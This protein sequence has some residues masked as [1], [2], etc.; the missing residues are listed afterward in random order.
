MILYNISLFLVTVIGGILPIWTNGLN[1]KNMHYLLAF[2][3]SFLLSITFLHLLPE[4]FAALGGSTGMLLLAGFFIQLLIQRLT[5]GTEHGH[6]H[7]SDH[8]HQA[9]LGS[10]AIGLV[11]HAIMDGVPL[12]AH[13]YSEGTISSLYL[14]IASHKLPEAMLV[15]SLVRATRNKAQAFYILLIFSSITPA[16]AIITGYM[17]NTYS[18]ASRALPYLIPIVAG[19]FINIATTIFFESGTRQHKLSWQ[20]VVAMLSGV[21]FGFLTLCFE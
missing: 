4:T 6:V 2:S 21:G 3:G 20:M 18:L 7:A 19:A 13:T 9:L 10:V 1:A 5:H 17:A 14:A 11:I 8:A 16:A 15:A 12:G